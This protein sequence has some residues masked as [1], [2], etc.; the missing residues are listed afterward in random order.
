MS[1]N[2]ALAHTLIEEG[3][4]V[5]DPQ[6]PGGATNK[7]VTQAVY[8]RYRRDAGLPIRSVRVID[9]AEVLDIYDN[10]YWKAGQ[11]DWLAANVSEKLAMVHFDLCVNA[12]IRQASVI[13][14]RA[15][16][17]SP[18]GIIGPL[19][20]AAIEREVKENE[21]EVLIRQLKERV[22]FY[23]ALVTQRPA[24]RK[25]LRGWFLRTYRLARKVLG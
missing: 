16:N 4:Y 23:I 15:V 22:E 10:R 2:K 3:G 20:R 6:D 12:G 8:D 18:D 5:N 9:D 7:G 17:A 24:L 14:Q 25:F 19:T 1:F 11:C 21:T 13:L